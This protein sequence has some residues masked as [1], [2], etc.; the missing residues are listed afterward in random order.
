MVC[1]FGSYLLFLSAPKGEDDDT[2]GYSGDHLSNYTLSPPPLPSA[3]PR[4][5]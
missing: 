5:S 1:V 3:P 4:F 2:M